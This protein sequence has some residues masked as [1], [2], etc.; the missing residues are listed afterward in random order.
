LTL[1]DRGLE[2][3]GV[4]RPSRSALSQPQPLDESVRVD[5]QAAESLH[6]LTKLSERGVM[7]V[8]RS[9]CGESRAS[10]ALVNR[11]PT[12]LVTYCPLSATR[13]AN[14]ETVS[15]A[16]AVRS[17]GTPQAEASTFKLLGEPK[18]SAS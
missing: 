13:P 14:S 3:L 12:G 7:H 16:S 15:T 1:D 17:I 8:A 2:L 10:V 18:L 5:T 6:D 4:V 11:K 9:R